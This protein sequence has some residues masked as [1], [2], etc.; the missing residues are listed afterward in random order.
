MALGRAKSKLPSA[1]KPSSWPHKVLAEQCTVNNESE[2]SKKLYSGLEAHDIF[3][4]SEYSC[5]KIAE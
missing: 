1:S 2:A 5:E 3:L 4:V